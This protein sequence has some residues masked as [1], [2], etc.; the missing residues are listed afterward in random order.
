VATTRWHDRTDRWRVGG[1][2]TWCLVLSTILVMLQ[3]GR[4]WLSLPNAYVCAIE[5]REPQSVRSTPEGAGASP[6]PTPAQA[7]YVVRRPQAYDTLPSL[8]HR[9]EWVVLRAGFDRP[10]AYCEDRNTLSST[11]VCGDAGLVMEIDKHSGAFRLGLEPRMSGLPRAA[12]VTVERG[13]CE[14]R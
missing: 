3:I 12:I 1:Y 8:S 14:R 4:W 2:G 11:I 7:S 6:S 5:S 9:I 13:I 10:I